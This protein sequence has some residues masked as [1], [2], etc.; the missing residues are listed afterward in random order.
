MKILKNVRNRKK[1]NEKKS[2]L[3]FKNKIQ[4]GIRTLNIKVDVGKSWS[5]AYKL[6]RKK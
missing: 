4:T 2:Q 5:K 1:E 6:L 3:P